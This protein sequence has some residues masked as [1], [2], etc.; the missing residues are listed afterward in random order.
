MKIL[1]FNSHAE[2]EAHMWD[3]VRNVV[4]LSIGKPEDD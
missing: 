1:K 2:A 4:G 3:F